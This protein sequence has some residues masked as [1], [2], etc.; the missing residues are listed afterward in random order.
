M[1]YFVR[2][3]LESYVGRE[4][5][6]IAYL[7]P[8]GTSGEKGRFHDE[9]EEVQFTKITDR[10]VIILNEYTSEDHLY[11]EEILIPIAHIVA[12]KVLKEVEQ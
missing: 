12:F 8:M 5:N 2:A 10:C 7:Y 9:F 1:S 6:Y 4:L 11:S 3:D